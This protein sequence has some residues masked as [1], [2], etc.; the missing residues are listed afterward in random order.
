MEHRSGSFFPLQHRPQPTRLA[1]AGCFAA[2]EISSQETLLPLS[3]TLES[4]TSLGRFFALARVRACNAE[5]AELDG[6]PVDS[7]SWVDGPATGM[8]VECPFTQTSLSVAGWRAGLKDEDAIED[9][10]ARRPLAG[11]GGVRHVAYVDTPLCL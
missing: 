11:R 2:L 4:P 7:T 9:R 6:L 3:A 1:S 5:T 8:E 10:K